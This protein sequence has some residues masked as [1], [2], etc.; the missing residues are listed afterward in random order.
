[1]K[2]SI[3]LTQSPKTE[4]K[5][6]C[7]FRNGFFAL[8]IGCCCLGIDIVTKYY[9]QALLPLASL[10]SPFYP[11]GGIGVFEDFYG[12][13][14][15]LNHTINLGAAWGVF[16]QYHQVLLVFRF[17]MVAGLLMYALFIN[18]DNRRYLP[19]AL[20][21]A[22]ASGNILDHFLYGHVIDM[23]HFIFW[24]YNYPVFNIADSCIFIGIAWLFL[25]S[26]CHSNTQS[27]TKMLNNA[28]N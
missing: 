23:F 27:Q 21:I 3:P 12:I 22:G 14:F 10:S 28:K 2:S 16:K 4:F 18:K 11:Y 15:T 19:L 1:V 17:V 20:V 24:G 9:T 7:L 13:Q 6:F 8:F 26:F 25:L 5:R